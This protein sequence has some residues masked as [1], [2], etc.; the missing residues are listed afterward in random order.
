M[1]QIA[2]V[3]LKNF[4][5]YCSRCNFQVI[6]RK[7]QDNQDRLFTRLRATLTYTYSTLLQI[8]KQETQGYRPNQNRLKTSFIYFS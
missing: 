3:D 1:T 2:N 5:Q 7:E 6:E 8:N 4:K